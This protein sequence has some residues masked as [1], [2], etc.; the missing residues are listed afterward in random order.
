VIDHKQL[1]GADMYGGRVPVQ[2]FSVAWFGPPY[3][4]WSIGTRYIMNVTSPLRVAPA[5]NAGHWAVLTGVVDVITKEQV[6]PDAINLELLGEM[7]PDLTAVVQC[8]HA[9]RAGA[10][11]QERRE[12]SSARRWKMDK[13]GVGGFTYHVLKIPTKATG[14]Q[15]TGTGGSHESPRFH[16]RRAHIRKLSSGQLTFVRQCFVGDAQAG[17]VSKHYQLKT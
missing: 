7:L 3:G 1:P 6:H 15:A 16:V 8:C 14:H 9:L 4:V 17:S 2:L 10:L 5:N 11:F 13:H 12:T